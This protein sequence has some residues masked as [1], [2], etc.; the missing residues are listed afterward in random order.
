MGVFF[1]LVE[2]HREGTEIN[3]AT[4]S[5]FVSVF[6]QNIPK[7]IFSTETCSK[8]K[9]QLWLLT[10]SQHSPTVTEFTESHLK[11]PYRFFIPSVA[12]TVTLDPDDDNNPTDH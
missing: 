11:V 4:Q 6:G 8:T 2:A 3:R 5:S 1:L 9:L 10:E 7:K 12:K